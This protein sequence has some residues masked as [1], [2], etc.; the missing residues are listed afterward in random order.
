M[1]VT[2]VDISMAYDGQRLD[3]FLIRHCKGVPKARIYRAIRQG[4]VRIDGKRAK[5]ST[6]LATGVRLRVPPMQ[7]AQVR[8]VGFS[9]EQLAAVKNWVLFENEDIVV[10]NKPSGIAVHGGT[11]VHYG[12][13][14][15]IKAADPATSFYLVHRLDR[16]TSG[17]LILAKNRPTLLLLHQAL[18]DRIIEK[19]Y[20]AWLGGAW[21]FSEDQCVEQPLRRLTQGDAGRKVVVSGLGQAAISHFYVE[22][23]FLDSTLVRVKIETGRMHQIRVHAAYLGH[24]VLGD[25]MYGDKLLNK[26]FIAQHGVVR[27]CLHARSLSLNCFDEPINVCAPLPS[28]LQVLLESLQ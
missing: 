5:A 26:R 21:R 28:D 9:H 16:G 20:L 19:S 17:C 18:R 1:P 7:T 10:I 15:L 22:Q 23:R 8:P 13:I 11:S 6:R 3:N 24:P 12:I 27:L 14:D 25:K 2:W 4:E